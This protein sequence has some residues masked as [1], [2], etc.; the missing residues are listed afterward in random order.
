[1]SPVSN[2]YFLPT[3][4]MGGQG[5]KTAANRMQ[6][7][8]SPCGFCISRTLGIDTLSPRAYM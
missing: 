2:M 6:R 3:F 1:M 5:L 7:T 4:E 8:Y